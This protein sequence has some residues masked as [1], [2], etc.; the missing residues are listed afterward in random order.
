MSDGQKVYGEG[1]REQTKQEAKRERQ[2]QEELEAIA[3]ARQK[4]KSK[5]K[6]EERTQGLG[7]LNGSSLHVPMAHRS[8]MVTPSLNFSTASPNSAAKTGSLS[9]LFSPSA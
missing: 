9:P 8:S 1:L 6:K 2:R 4:H 3:S 5:Q 7:V